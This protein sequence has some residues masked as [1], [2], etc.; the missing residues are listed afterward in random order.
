MPPRILVLNGPNLNLLGSRE[1]EIYGRATLAE[2][3]A[4]AR[5][6]AEAAGASLE[7]RQSNHEGVL[8]D[9]IQAAREGADGLAI[10]P[11]GLTH[12]SIALADALAAFPGPIVEVHLSN[13]HRREPFRRRSFVSAVAT[14]VLCGFGIRGYVLAVTVLLDLLADAATATPSPR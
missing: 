2:A 8:I 10:N 12:S 6:V 11:G 5:R 1:P 9:W 14:G 7:W 3:E 4:A 13:I